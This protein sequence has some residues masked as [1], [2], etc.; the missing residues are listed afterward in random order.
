MRKFL[1]ARVLLTFGLVSLVVSAVLGAAFLGLVPDRIGAVRE[2]RALTAELVAATAMTNLH[3]EQRQDL[4]N[5]LDFALSRNKQMLSIGV[6]VNDGATPDVGSLMVTAGPHAT[7]WKQRSG[8]HSVENQ[9]MVPINREGGRWGQIEMV[10]TQLDHPGWFGWMFDDKFLLVAA[11]AL[12]CTTSFY[13]YLGRMLRHLDPGRAVPERVK[14]ALDSLAESLILMDQN[15]YIVLANQSFCD[16]TGKTVEHLLGKGAKDFA[17]LDQQGEPLSDDNMPWVNVFK[18]GLLQRD[19]FV[20]MKDGNGVM[21]SFKSNAA[22]VPGAAGK[23]GGVLMS[24]DDITV[25]EQKEVELRE[26][27]AKADAASQAKSDFLANMSH[28]IRTPMNAIIGFTELLRRGVHRNEN[29]ATRYLNT[30]HSNGKHLLELIND[31]LDLSKVEAG[32]LEVEKI[33]CEP[34]N[35]IK[36]VIDILQVKAREKAIG[37]EFVVTGPVPVSIHSDPA[38]LRQMVT[39]LVG[40]AIKFTEKGQVRVHERW[41]AATRNSAARLEIDVS[42]SGI[43]I[44]ADKLGSIFEAFVQ[45]ESSTT[46]R[47]GGTGLGLSI[48]RSFAQVLGGDIQVQ[49]VYG[50]GSTFTIV[51]D[52]G[53]EIGEL[54]APAAALKAR[55]ANE[56]DATLSWQFEA[57]EVLVVDDSPENRH[58]VKLVLEEV[59]LR[60]SEAGDGQQACDAIAAKRFDLV[61]MDMSMPVMDGY[62]ATKLLRQRGQSLPIIAFTAHA[63]KG[64]ETE[65]LAAGCTGYLTKPIDI[66]LM[67]KTL[68]RFL[69]ANRIAVKEKTPLLASQAS[70]DTDTSGITSRLAVN[71]KFHAVINAFIQR[72]NPQLDAMQTALTSANLEELSKLAH[73]LKGSGGSVG[74]DDFT[75]PAR[76]LEDAAK[77]G[78]IETA[79]KQ[80]NNI[81]QLSKRLLSPNASSTTPNSN[82]K[83][84]VRQLQELEV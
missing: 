45:A 40:N 48:S 55:E 42:D 22:P 71:A 53:Q 4:Q 18:T 50:E 69:P 2:G 56:S 70:R 13:F 46:R 51:L 43:G 7:Q 78:D 26:S 23:V 21:R 73:W 30:I 20:R 31:I 9:V 67:L 54:I 28:E 63:L 10:F 52:P 75:D 74:F 14:S 44:P 64:F 58:L 25:L 80:L 59:G 47:F 41:I 6:R 11:I 3:E 65:I 72:L 83:T 77:A 17:W 16:M 57:K 76:R 34:H 49:S 66:D 27:K 32:R 38:R 5:Y 19:V 82:N 84:P 62:T 68:N 33:H 79:R 61:L 12:F 81:A 15:G 35:V 37:L 36:D 24:M 8:D 60:V 1:N 29:E 39:N